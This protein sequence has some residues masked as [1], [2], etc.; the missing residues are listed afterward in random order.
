MVR[1]PQAA[2]YVFVIDVSHRSVNLGILPTVVQ[3]IKESIDQLPGD[4]RTM[5]GFVTF[6]STIHFYHL[7]STLS[8]PQML[9]VSDGCS[10]NSEEDPFLPLPADLLVNLKES[11]HLVDML[12]ERLPT[13]FTN[14]VVHD[15]ALGPTLKAVEYMM[16]PIGGKMMVFA[17]GLATLGVGRLASRY[18]QRMLG[19]EQKEATLLQEAPSP[20]GQN[21]Y[22]DLS[23]E[24]SKYQISV[25]MFLFSP[26]YTDLASL[27]Q[28]P[29]YTGGQLYHYQ[30]FELGR[31]GQKLSTDLKRNLTRETGFEAVMRVRCS[32]GMKV[33]GFY[34]NF[35]LKGQDLMALPNIDADKAFG[36]EL[37][38]EEQML[39]SNAICVQCAL[40][41]T[42]SKGERRIRVHTINLAVTSQMIDL[43]NWTDVDATANLTARAGIDTF[44]SGRMNDG[45]L[46]VQERC[47]TAIRGFKTGC[48]PDANQFALLPPTMD[49]I[50]LMTLSTLKHPIIRA[51][52]D[53]HPDERIWMQH[54][55]MMMSATATA[56]LLYP[57]VY[58]LH[59]MPPTAG[60]VGGDGEVEMPP[61]LPL[62][63]ERLE[64]DG[65]FFMF[66][67]LVAY[68]ILGRAVQP[69]LVQQILG[70]MPIDRFDGYKIALPVLPNQLSQRLHNIFGHL[71]KKLSTQPSLVL[72]RQGG[73][74]EVRITGLMVEDRSM[75]T[76]AYVEFLQYLVRS[77]FSSPAQN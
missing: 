59:N 61:P 70:D 13:M 5:I 52:N 42:T 60:N 37:G 65:A 23:L 8:Q 54:Q 41:Y 67:G 36:C 4:E 77:A 2:C 62:A 72:V 22:K 74:A 14:T 21:F 33:T 16:N 49:Q 19:N 3:T 28:L 7:K 18:D 12:L 43:Y 76:M 75:H 15:L 48:Q 26:Q 45:R 66:D 34:G 24:C 30:A 58:S 17:S 56:L 20:K 35:L 44:A 64:P 47:T 51:G 31:D 55:V 40:L 1:P 39:T 69:G 10:N 11:R 46:K 71:K 57:K 6:D 50:P 29:K 73:P 9:V 25:D 68:L 32:K 38:Y 27:V 63:M 53:T